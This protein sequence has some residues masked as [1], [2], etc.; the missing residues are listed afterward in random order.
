MIVWLMNGSLDVVFCVLV[1]SVV[2]PRPY[3][4]VFY[5]LELCVVVDCV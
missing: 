3:D 4:V 2:M 1:C 5:C